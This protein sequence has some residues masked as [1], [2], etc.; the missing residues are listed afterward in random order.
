MAISPAELARRTGINRVYAWQLLN[1]KRSPSPEMALRIYE[2]TGLQL[3]L[4]EGLDEEAVERIAERYPDEPVNYLLRGEAWLTAGES[5]RAASDFESGI[6][7]LESQRETVEKGEQRWGVLDAA[8]E[9]FD[10]AGTPVPAI[11]A[12]APQGARRMS[13]RPGWE[14]APWRAAAS[15]AISAWSKSPRRRW[16]SPCR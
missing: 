11:Q 3:G 14:E 6:A 4:L 1:D 10:E 9:L 5:D 16:I 13:A 8:E 12:T 2:Q 7:L 15:Y